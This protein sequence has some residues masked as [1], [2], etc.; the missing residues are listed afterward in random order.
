MKFCIACSDG[1]HLP[2]GASASEVGCG[3][4]EGS[5]YTWLV[6]GATGSG[7]LVSWAMAVGFNYVGIG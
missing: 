2:L 5:M 3:A 7:H 4:G 1:L 6:E